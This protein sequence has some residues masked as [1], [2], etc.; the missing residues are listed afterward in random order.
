MSIMVL[1]P[2]PRAPF[3]N[4]APWVWSWSALLAMGA[5][6]LGLNIIRPVG[7]FLLR[8]IGV[9]FTSWWGELS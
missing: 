6:F 8:E 7:V 9:S 1:I 5:L 4:G 2:F 3:R